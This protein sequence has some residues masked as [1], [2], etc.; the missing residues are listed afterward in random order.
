MSSILP[1]DVTALTVST[2]VRLHAAQSLAGGPHN[3]E[4]FCKEIARMMGTVQR[5]LLKKIRSYFSCVVV[6]TS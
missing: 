4:V 6:L 1:T 5:E 3:Y 2:V